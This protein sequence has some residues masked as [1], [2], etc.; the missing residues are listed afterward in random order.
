MSLRPLRRIAC[1]GAPSLKGYGALLVA[2]ALTALMAPGC[3]ALLAGRTAG[4]GGVHAEAKPTV[5]DGEAT[6]LEAELSAAGQASDGYV[7]GSATSHRPAGEDSGFPS[8]PMIRV[9]L[10]HG[11]SEARATAAGAF[12]VS[13]Y[14]EET[15]SWSCRG[16]DEWTFRASPSRLRGANGS[17]SFDI[18]AGTVRL[19]P[20]GPW[21]VVY[22]GVKY[23]GELE[24]YLDGAGGLAVV[25]VV[26][27]ESYLRGVVPKEIGPRPEIEI[28][29][30]KAQAVAARTYAVASWGKREDGDF[31]VFSTVADQVYGGRDVE[32]DV[33]DRAISETAGVVATYD[34]VPVY[35]YFFAN[36][37]GKTAARDD[38]WELPAEPY[39]TSVDDRGRGSNGKPFCRDGSRHTWT[40]EWTGAELE[41]AV[42]E[43]LPNVASTPV[44]GSVGRVEGLRVT[45]RTSSGRVKW[46]EVRTDAGTYRVFGDK[47]RWLL[48]RPEGGILW[49]AWFDL[50][51]DMRG[52]RVASLR[53]E[54]RGYG[55]GVGMC[56]HGAI[57]M[58]RAGY[59]FEEILRHYYKGVELARIE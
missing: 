23:R 37:G 8:G 34:G 17:G 40:V 29:A 55:H 2:V 53:A 33:C 50:D 48:R 3:T 52:G 41:S 58:A 20:T 11:L 27:L 57:G 43:A 32:N 59:G 1:E 15:R 25:N 13:V 45:G 10:G 5:A 21:P 24:L 16:G 38:V 51:V 19:T 35:A 18:D 56:Q 44:S 46:L 14:S 28:E 6:S 54:G 47:V 7:A 22:D 42:R 39:L 49:S 9:G 36:C 30:V 4:G 31:D 12:D 26:D